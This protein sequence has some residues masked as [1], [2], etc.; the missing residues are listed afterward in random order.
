M[1][2]RTDW[3]LYSRMKQMM[4]I[5]NFLFPISARLFFINNGASIINAVARD[6]SRRRLAHRYGL[7]R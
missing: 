2:S 7:V 1:L 4:L 6:R 5:L 3:Y